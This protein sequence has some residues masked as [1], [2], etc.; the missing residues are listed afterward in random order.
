MAKRRQT[1][2]LPKRKSRS[3]EAADAEEAAD[4]SV[5]ERFGFGKPISEYRTRAERE[6]VIQ[7]RVTVAVVATLVF[8]VAILG[9]AFLVDQVLNPAREVATIDGQ[10]ISAGDFEDRVRFE[11]LVIIER[12][13][14]AADELIQAQGLSESDAAN[15]A[16]STNQVL[17]D[18][19]EVFRNNDQMGLRV[20]NTMIEDQLILDYAEENSIEVTQEMIDDQ[21]QQLLG[22]DA[23]ENA[24]LLDPESTLEPTPENTPTP[25]PFV[26]PTPSPVPTSTPEG[27]VGPTPTPSPIPTVSSART[28]EP[29][30]DR[31][32]FENNLDRFYDRANSVANFSRSDVDEWFRVQAIRE[33]V[34][35]SVVEEQTTETWVDA[36]RIVVATEEEALEILSALQTGESF[37]ELARALSQD[38]RSASR[39]GEMGSFPPNGVTITPDFLEAQLGVE[40]DY[41]EALAE[42]EVGELIGPV[43]AL[44]TDPQGA[45]N[46]GYQIIQIREREERDLEDEQVEQLRDEAFEEWLEDLRDQNSEIIDITDVWPDVVPDGPNYLPR[47]A[48]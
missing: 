41:L 39:G 33:A 15:Q 37:S 47:S 45:T 5:A 8:V 21:I 31:Q 34:R 9:I 19:F 7:R 13:N 42:G 10:E 38:T 17:L 43:N 20:V 23:E 32:V 40:R 11:R 2:R 4:Q 25:T 16:L 6:Q 18:Q 44:I 14:T 46:P 1:S 48:Q 27:E 36:R 24:I 3:E 29:E 12:V 35:N 30:L 26:S 22:F 28:R